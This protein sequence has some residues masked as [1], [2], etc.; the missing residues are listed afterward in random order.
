MPKID[1]GTER[2]V[3]KLLAKA[4]GILM[5]AKSLGI[6]TGTGAARVS[7]SLA[8]LVAEPLCV[9]PGRGKCEI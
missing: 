3:R 1:S 6:G 5:V 4:I 7:T 8:E 2:K 9:A